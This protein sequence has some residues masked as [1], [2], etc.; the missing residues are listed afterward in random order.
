MSDIHTGDIIC[1]TCGLV[2]DVNYIEENKFNEINKETKTNEYD[3]IETVI[4]HLHLPKSYVGFI[5]KNYVK[6]YKNIKTHDNMKKISDCIYT[7][8]N[9][10]NNCISIKDLTKICGVKSNSIKNKLTIHDLNVLTDKYLQQLYI[11][12]KDRSVIKENVNEKYENTG[13]NPLT[14]IA[15][16][17]YIYC[18][19]NRLKYSM[20]KIANIIGISPIS[21]QR[22]LKNDTI[23]RRA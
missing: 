16:I 15:S 11:P 2:M 6:K 20:I 19:K 22:F 12:Y 5:S 4:D 18:K 23:S 13:Y 14:I 7:T 9:D 8:V 3:I 17:L 10:I 1:T 21:I